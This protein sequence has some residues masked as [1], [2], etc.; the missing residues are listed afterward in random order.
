MFT[1]YWR[2]AYVA[3]PDTNTVL[4]K[5]TIYIL[6]YRSCFFPIVIG[7][8]QSP[9]LFIVRFGSQYVSIKVDYRVV[10]VNSWP[11]SGCLQ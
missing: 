4:N 5:E 9:V 1:E 10:Y 7:Q 3:G 11:K 8:S 6:R 2:A